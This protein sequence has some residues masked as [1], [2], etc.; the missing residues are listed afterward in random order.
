MVNLTS[1]LFDLITAN[2]ILHYHDVV[3]AY[4]HI[5]VR[6]PD[7]PSIFV[8]S[9]NRAP[10]IVSQSSDF[11]HYFVENASSVDP[12]APRGYIER[13]I[14]SELYKRF[15]NVSTVIHAHAEAVTSFASSGVPLK[16]VFHMPS[17][18]GAYIIHF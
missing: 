2:H 11:V 16:P 9:G 5:S 7:D 15:S 17:F 14:H 1:L 12:D 4:G 3:D 13:Y 8:L 10:A 18:L 6:H